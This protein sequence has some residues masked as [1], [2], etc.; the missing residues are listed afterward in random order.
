MKH[1]RIR[2]LVV[3]AIAIAFQVG[4]TTPSTR[5]PDLDAQTVD[6]E[7]RKQLEV[8]FE[9]GL[10]YHD[11]TIKVAYPLLKAAVPLCSTDT[12]YTLGI[13]PVNKYTLSK[14]MRPILEASYGIGEQLVI[15]SIPPGSPADKA[16][17]RKG[18]KILALG[19][20]QPSTGHKANE[21]WRELEAQVLAAGEP[22]TL[23]IIRDA[24][25]VEITL[26]P[27]QICNYMVY[28]NFSSDVNAYA[29][30][31]AVMLTAG[32]LRFVNNDEELAM[33]L[34]HE[35]AHNVM[36]HMS[37]RQSNYTAGSV[38]DIVAAVAGVNT[39]GAFGAVG[40]ASYSKSFE[41]EADY[42]GLYIMAMAGMPIDE[43]PVLWRRMAATQTTSGGFLASHPT[44]SERYVALDRTI[45]EIHAK[46][47]KKELL[48]PNIKN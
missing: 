40:A 23:S 11:R 42:V 33:V 36:E 20:Q 27:D 25:Q 17:L 3:L 38:L 13:D 8:M 4:C 6:E 28:E 46:Q 26:V 16:G 2:K 18:D 39:G 31:E 48:R 45:D 15:L 32:M 21:A 37:A 43:A 5:T 22:V 19:G 44:T 9:T 7:T 14:S 10:A 12:V 30:G 41:S 1:D 47:E 29:S 24:E 34:A 35:I